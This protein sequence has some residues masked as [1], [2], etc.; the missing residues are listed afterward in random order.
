[1][2]GDGEQLVDGEAS[3]DERTF[4]RELEALVRRAERN[5]VSVEG[6]WVCESTERRRWEIT[7]VSVRSAVSSDSGEDDG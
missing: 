1:M 2:N 7:A 6:P 4:R 3:F 5:G